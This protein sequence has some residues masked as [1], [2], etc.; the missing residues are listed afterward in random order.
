MSVRPGSIVRFRHRRW[1]VLP[2]DDE[3]IVL[4]RPLTGTSE[5]ALPVHRQLA[6]LL[7]YSLPSERLEADRFPLPDPTQLTDA[8]A[9]RL[10]GQAARL[11]LREGAAPLRSLGRIS[12]RPR[13]Y[14][15]VPLLMALR[16]DPVRLLIADDVGVGKTIEAGLIARELWDTG[17]I[18][19][20]A[21]L[22][23]PPLTEQWASELREKF[24]LDP[25]ILAPHSVAAL[26]RTLPPGRSL[27]RHYP[28]IVASI[29]Y[30]KLPRNREPFL[31]EPP[32]L[33]IVDEAHGVVPATT[34]ERDPRH[35]RYRLV[36]ELASDQRRHLIL[37]TATPHSGIQRAFQRLLG[38]LHTDFEDWDLDQ[39]DR[40]RTERLARH[41]VQRTRADISRQWPE[42][43]QLYPVRDAIERT[44]A[45]SDA[46]RA[47]FQDT[48]DFCRRLIEESR[49]LPDRERRF[50]WWAAL[51]LLR[52]VMSSPRAGAEALA[53][54][55]IPQAEEP[56]ELA[57]TTE[58]GENSF[59]PAEL[60][61]LEPTEF[62]PSDEIPSQRLELAT[63]HT[64]ALSETAR[65][66]LRELARQARA[67]E[68]DP[69]SDTKLQ[70]CLEA[71]RQLLD[72]GSA[73]VIWCVF[74]DT[75]EYVAERLR[76]ALEP[77]DRDLVVECL[78][79]R[80]D[81]QQRRERV[82]ALQQAPRRVLVATDCLSE[83]V[84]L[85]ELFDAVL[86]YDL[87]WNP[88]RLE[89]REGRVD[90]FGQPC[91]RVTAVRL[92]GRDNPVDAEVIDI[93]IRKADRIRRQLGIHVPVPEDEG[94]LAELLVHRLFEKPRQA[95][96]ALPI[97]P[98]PTEQLLSRWDADT[99][100]E[101][102][103]RTRF[104]QHALDP[105]VVTQHLASCDAV[106]GDE[107]TVR[108]FVAGASQRLGLAVDARPD[109][110]L[111][112]QTS[113]P[114]TVPEPI[115]LLLPSDR[116]RAWQ[117]AFTVPHP[118]GSEWVGR[119]HPFTV[120]L[121]RYLFEIAFERP[122]EPIV[123]RAAVL[124]SR[125]VSQVATLALLRTRF[126]LRRPDR[127]EAVLE[128]V[129]VTGCDLFGE[130][131]LAPAEARR[132]LDQARPEDDIPLAERRELAATALEPLAES[133]A[134]TEPSGPL[135][136]LLAQ[137]AAELAEAHRQV[138]AAAGER[139]RSLTVE[140]LWPPDLIAFVVLQPKR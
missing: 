19:R 135:A 124:R 80:I 107:E 36:R 3:A 48:F 113:R 33:V 65:R 104:A 35:L 40:A 21:V 134:R 5:D 38:L 1:V 137:R 29:D 109:G 68:A 119:N 23:P 61:G 94:W 56:E 121:A 6:D 55:E 70:A 76:Q 128:D 12:V 59:E 118:P 41:V 9:V 123:A 79:G 47:L 78:T 96:L 93:L 58:L 129:L 4:L 133:L 75:A 85:Q 103:R 130:R 66:R 53:R 67:I 16:L 31:A 115:R 7:A 97:G 90:R 26:E 34:A 84:N 114:D 20:L 99:E 22:C 132:L 126:L 112:L 72:R 50:Q 28:V 27:F 39:L 44:Y 92:Y 37:L 81:D 98:D 122:T 10:L 51:T 89:Q 43:S 111:V 14:Q 125:L 105:Q 87:P 2:S 88:N 64:L 136:E 18:R 95:Q 131:W 77:T 62:R 11:L 52:C 100:R 13:P 46:Y 8:E 91:E 57:L 101:Q 71:V 117:L 102:R 45:L 74:V 73:P 140:P 110:T 120:G 127:P 83:G 138:L 42:A 54:R 108:A 69:A 86:H 24:H 106:L 49:Q 15:L 30:L 17:E 32:D 63:T 60:L 139:R 25:V 116:R 82:R